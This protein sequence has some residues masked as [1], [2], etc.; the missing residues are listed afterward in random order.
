MNPKKTSIRA[1]TLVELLVVISIIAILAALLMPGFNNAIKSAKG[2]KCAGNLKQIGAAMMAYAGE[3]NGVFPISGGA[4]D[5][6]NTGSGAIGWTQQLDKYLPTNGGTDLRI[7]QCPITSLLYPNSKN[8]GYFNGAHAA[9]AAAGNTSAALRQSL[10]QFPSKLIL[11]GDIA[12]N[13][14]TLTDTDKDD[15]TQ[16]PAFSDAAT[17]AKMHSGKSNILFADGHVAAFSTFDYSKAAGTANTDSDTRS[18]TVWYDTVADFN[19]KQ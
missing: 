15:Y 18:M 4:I 16:S 17:M 12:S 11:A 6:N 19:G 13:M 7:F 9:Y 14:F 2:T 5:Y 10:I 1:F 3:N 8:Y